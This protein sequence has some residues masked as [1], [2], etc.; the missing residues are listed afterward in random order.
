MPKD[1]QHLAPAFQLLTSKAFD[2]PWF[3]GPC[4]RFMAQRCGHWLFKVMLMLGEQE[5]NITSLSN[6]TPRCPLELTTSQ[7]ISLMR[8]PHL[9]LLLVPGIHINFLLLQLFKSWSVRGSQ[10][11]PYFSILAKWNPWIYS[12]CQD[13]MIS[14]NQI[15]TSHDVLLLFNKEAD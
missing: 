12:M 2:L 1:N 7:C 8:I 10:G 6:F 14:F 13:L 4:C 15:Q 11:L 3:L 5:Q 9:W